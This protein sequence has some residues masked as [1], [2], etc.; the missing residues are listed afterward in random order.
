VLNNVYGEGARGYSGRLSERQLNFVRQDLQHVP[1]DVLIVLSMHIPLANTKNR[2]QLLS[3]LKGRGDVLAIT[4]H[5]HQ[6]ARFFLDGDGVRV[7]ELSAGATCGFWWVGERG[8]DG[9]PS[10][11]QQC[12]TP[13]NYFVLD[14]DDTHY[15]MHCKAIGEDERHQMTLH[16]T[17]ID[18]LDTYLRDMKGVPHGLLM[19]TVYG[20]CDSTVVR[21]RIDGGEW[22]VCQKDSLLDSNVSRTR[23][24][25]L[26]KEYPTK[27]NRMNPMRHIASRQLW[28]LPLPANC[29]RGA[30]TVEVE[31]E[32]PW[33]FR[34][35]GTRSFCFPLH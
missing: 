22:L 6:V 11:L 35:T 7:H 23:E 17:G 30:H 29:R 24:M 18:T 34:A 3:L 16:V 32:D 10:A 9:V 27:Y 15:S 25:N 12:G 28:T 33:G 13:R 26:L 14:F 1:Q 4:G 19:M 8:V 2:D 20:G 5:M 21:C 31:A